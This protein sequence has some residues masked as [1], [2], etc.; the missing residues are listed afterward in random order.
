MKPEQTGHPAGIG[1]CV[2]KTTLALQG[3][4]GSK[5]AP[6]QGCIRGSAGGVDLTLGLHFSQLCANCRGDAM[7]AHSLGRKQQEPI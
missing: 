2:L 1:I 4:Q 5:C 6:L 7:P 3:S